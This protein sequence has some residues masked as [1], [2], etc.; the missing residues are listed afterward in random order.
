M[1]SYDLWQ[2]VRRLSRFSCIV[3]WT[4]FWWQ[5][6]SSWCEDNSFQSLF[7]TLVDYLPRQDR[8]FSTFL[9]KSHI[10]GIGHIILREYI[11]W[12]MLTDPVENGHVLIESVQILLP[13]CSNLTLIESTI[14]HEIKFHHFIEDS[15]MYTHCK[16]K[17]SRYLC[18][19]HIPFKKWNFLSWQT[20]GVA[21]SCG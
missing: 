9:I 19:L 4:S 10:Y 5:R 2:A 20:V 6:T 3:E 12:L 11:T 17:I 1:M 18:N 8:L 7:I 15:S 16:I 21:V 13:N 14:C